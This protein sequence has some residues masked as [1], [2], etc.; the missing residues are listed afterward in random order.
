[1][2]KM[3]FA[4]APSN[5]LMRLPGFLSW[6]YKGSKMKLRTLS[7]LRSSRLPSHVSD[8]VFLASFVAD[9]VFV[10]EG[11]NVRMAGNLEAK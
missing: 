6:D 5:P 11:C 3:R 10:A 9:S 4:R 1:M 8:C 7:E 2:V